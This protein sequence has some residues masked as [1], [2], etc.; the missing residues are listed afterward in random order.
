MIEWQVI[1]GGGA[2]DSRHR[3]HLPLERAM[4][5]DHRLS[6]RI[7]VLTQR[8]RHR[9]GVFGLE[10]Q[11]DCLHLI[12]RLQHQRGAH[13]QHEGESDLADHQGFLQPQAA[14]G[15]RCRRTALLERLAD[16]HT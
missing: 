3:A 1:G 15:R 12:E 13:E 5:L 7:A 10:S 9:Q 16:R 6:L 14:A 11:I 2:D 8:H 4:K